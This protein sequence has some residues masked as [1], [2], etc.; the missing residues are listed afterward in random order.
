M[1]EDVHR[2]LASYLT[3]YYDYRKCLHNC[4]YFAD[5]HFVYH[6]SGASRDFIGSDRDIFVYKLWDE[7]IISLPCRLLPFYSCN[8][9][10][11]WF[12]PSPS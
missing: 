12:T 8:A 11:V 4:I 7:N 2:I 3:T 1:F 5:D 10:S 9:H 6:G